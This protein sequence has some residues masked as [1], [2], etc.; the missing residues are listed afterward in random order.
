MKLYSIVFTIISLVSLS[1]KN[2]TNCLLD[3]DSLMILVKNSNPV[4]AEKTIPA[5]AGRR[6]VLQGTFEGLS[7]DKKKLNFR[8]HYSDDI[9]RDDQIR[10]LQDGGVLVIPLQ[11]QSNQSLKK[12]DLIKIEADIDQM[13]GPWPRD[14]H[15]IMR[16]FPKKGDRRVIV[17]TGMGYNI[18]LKNAIIISIISK[19]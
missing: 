12:G 15:G 8:Q 1:A 7:D 4:A 18:T 17:G 2:D 10:E 11:Q 13:N 16:D 19:K 14:V 6:I 3:W 5:A 9:E